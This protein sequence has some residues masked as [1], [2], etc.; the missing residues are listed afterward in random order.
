LIP[1]EEKQKVAQVKALV[2]QIIT[3]KDGFKLEGKAI[4]SKNDLLIRSIK[5]G[6]YTTLIIKRD[7]FLIKPFFIF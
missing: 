1:Q 6:K 3:H 5:E 7:F 2:K 4:K